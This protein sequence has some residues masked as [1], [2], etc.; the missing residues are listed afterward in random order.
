MPGYGPQHDPHLVAWGRADAPASLGS[1]LAPMLPAPGRGVAVQLLGFDGRALPP[2]A[3]ILSP[4]SSVSW[5]GLSPA[6]AGIVLA[7][8]TP[9]HS[10]CPPSLGPGGIVMH[11][12]VSPA[13]SRSGSPSAMCGSPPEAFGAGVGA[14]WRFVLDPWQQLQQQ[15]PLQQQKQQAQQ[16]QLQ[17]QPRMQLQMPPFVFPQPTLTGS[18][19]VSPSAGSATGSTAVPSG[20]PSARGHL[21]SPAVPLFRALSPAAGSIVERPVSLCLN[22]LDPPPA[23]PVPQRTVAPDPRRQASGLL[24][25]LP[26]SVFAPLVLTST[27]GPSSPAASSLRLLVA[28]DSPLT[29]SRRA[30]APGFAEALEAATAPGHRTASSSSA[31]RLSSGIGSAPPQFGAAAGSSACA[32]APP[33]GKQAITVRSE[34]VKR[35][36]INKDGIITKEEIEQAVALMD[37]CKKFCEEAQRANKAARAAAAAAAAGASRHGGVASPAAGG[38]ALPTPRRVLQPEE[39]REENVLPAPSPGVYR[40]PSEG[41]LHSMAPQPELSPRSGGWSPGTVQ[42]NPG[43]IHLSVQSSPMPG[44]P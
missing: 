3:P 1:F 30:F 24:A 7:P 34:L 42:V 11:G 28:M 39:L 15:Q 6:P 29:T 41:S 27:S 5:R 31:P 18:A 16:Q 38:L 4:R 20:V 8:P 17:Q 10:I 19:P 2:P 33:P 13:G 25:A 14:A 35:P 9:T 22:G 43:A 32:G 21:L 26:P 37:E 44:R 40:T 36:D 23:L 12:L